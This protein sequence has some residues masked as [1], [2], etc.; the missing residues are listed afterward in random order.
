MDYFIKVEGM[1]VPEA[2]MRILKRI[3][4]VE[5]SPGASSPPPISSSASLPR[6][7][8]KTFSLPPQNHTHERAAQYLRKRGIDKT[9]IDY[10][11]K[12][13]R[14][15]ESCEKRPSYRHMVEIHNVVFVGFDKAGTPRYGAIRGMMGRFHGDV[16]GSDKRWSF[17]IQPSQASQRLHLFECGIDAL[18]YATQLHL[19]GQNW[20]ADHLLS[21]AG[22]YTP[23]KNVTESALPRA[24][25]QY[26]M[27]YP[28]IKE[29]DLHLDRDTAGRLAS[30]TISALLEQKYRVRDTPPKRGKD[31]NESLCL[32]LGIV[33]P[34]VVER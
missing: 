13:K 6:K 12:T 8:K 25:S 9:I 34:R 20:R 18:S 7:E 2:G 29:I 19:D 22:V 28:Q 33:K 3:G 26:L 31:E 21:L 1:S 27:D 11:F 14:L 23:R 24:L 10:C 17:S 15:Y 16:S 32:R 5:E 30:K 4:Q